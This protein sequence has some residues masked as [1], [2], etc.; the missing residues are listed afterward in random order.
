M[1]QYVGPNEDTPDAYEAPNG[2]EA[3]LPGQADTPGSR[4][5][6]ATTP[7]GAVAN[8]MAQW[9]ELEATTHGQGSQVGYPVNL[10][11]NNEY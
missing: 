4:D 8:S 10:P 5:P 3:V 11:A 9:Q 1:I 6:S 2:M 7:A